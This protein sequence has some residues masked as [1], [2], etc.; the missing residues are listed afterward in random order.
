MSTP[1]NPAGIGT[2][3]RL[4]GVV[5]VGLALLLLAV[6]LGVRSQL[7]EHARAMAES[8]LGTLADSKDRE[9]H[10]WLGDLK[11]KNARP[12]DDTL[13]SLL[14]GR[15][16]DD[17]SVSLEQRLAWLVQRSDEFRSAWL[18]DRDG[19]AVAVPVVAMPLSLIGA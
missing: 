10:H 7:M 13:A 11:L 15:S 3:A 8:T 16:P 19:R 1:Q 5:L 6:S 18:L 12:D 2:T 4:Y 14:A 17:P 9:L